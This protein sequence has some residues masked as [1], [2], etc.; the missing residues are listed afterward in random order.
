MTRKR[1][2]I[3]IL[4]FIML[5]AVLPGCDSQDFVPTEPA[6]TAEPALR[7]ETLPAVPVTEPSVPVTEQLLFG[8]YTPADPDL[9][10]SEAIAKH[11]HKISYSPQ[12]PWSV[13]DW[14][15]TTFLETIS[16]EDG[17][18]NL[19]EVTVRLPHL[20]SGKRF[21]MEYNNS[22]DS[23]ASEI[24]AEVEECAE[25]A[26]ST[27]IISVDYEA[28]LNDDTLSILITTKTAT[29]YIEYRVDNFDLDDGEYMTTAEMCDE[30]LDME[31]PQFLKY[32]RNK[33]M[34]DFETG[35]ADFIAQFPEEYEFI[36]DLYLSYSSVPLN[37]RLYRNE[38]GR[39]MLVCDR[40]SVAGADYYSSIEEMAV[41]PAL[42]PNEAEA[43]DWLFNL[44]L[45]A[46]EESKTYASELLLAA[47]M[48]DGDDFTEALNKRPGSEIEAIRA[49]IRVKYNTEG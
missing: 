15:A 38:N 21:A 26:C 11:N 6:A 3:F 13:D 35:H 46:E 39:L 8:E 2:F 42:V 25:T 40:P 5:T 31:Y 10:L 47:Y 22:I 30:Y 29:D 14:V 27:H 33:I 23:F 37:Y 24:I 18:G 20:H 49:A 41:D 17:V 19:N 16:W 45:S 43:W 12:R 34:Q 36:K 1:V 28:W 48:E 44:Y 32:T 4:S 9:K 7:C